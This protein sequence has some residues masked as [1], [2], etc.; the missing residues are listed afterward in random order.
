MT[1]FLPKFFP[2]FSKNAVLPWNLQENMLD[3]TFFLFW[4]ACH[5]LLRCFLHSYHTFSTP[6]PNIKS[7]ERITHCSH[8]SWSGD[9]GLKIYYV[10]YTCYG[11]LVNDT[12]DSGEAQ[13]LVTLDQN[14]LLHLHDLPRNLFQ[15]CGSSCWWQSSWLTCHGTRFENRC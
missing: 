13:A 6:F 14:P 8:S 4:Y 10:E 9:V 7:I 1:L 3:K 2:H 11:N 12:S 15:C 5:F